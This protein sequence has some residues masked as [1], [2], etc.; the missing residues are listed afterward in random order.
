[1]QTSIAMTELQTS[2]EFNERYI[3][4]TLTPELVDQ[5]LRTNKIDMG[6][7]DNYMKKS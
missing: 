6:T 3:E 7:Y 5:A 1:M 2:R 4:G